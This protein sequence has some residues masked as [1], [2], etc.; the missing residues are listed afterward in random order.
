MERKQT[1]PTMAQAVE[2]IGTQILR[3][4]QESQLRFMAE[5]QGEKFANQVWAKAVEAGKVRSK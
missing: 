2:I 5:T 3:K 1:L 4:S